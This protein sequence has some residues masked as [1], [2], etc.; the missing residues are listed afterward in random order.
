MDN[1]YFKVLFQI[2]KPK[3]QYSKTRIFVTLHI[4]VLYY[5]L[6]LFLFNV[7]KLYW[8]DM[9]LLPFTTVEY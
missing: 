6:V 7:V 8:I 9:F 3:L 1:S 4:S 2:S 5:R